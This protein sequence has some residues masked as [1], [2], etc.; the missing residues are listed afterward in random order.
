MIGWLFGPAV[1]AGEWWRVITSAFLH[2]SFIHIGFN[3]YVLWAIGHP[4]LEGIGRV[5]FLLVYL[6]GLL[7]ASFAVLAFD[8]TAP[9]LGASG[10]VLGLAGAL[11]AVLWSRGINITQTSLGFVLLLNL[12]LP[13]LIGG[14][15]F[16]GH[17]GGIF[18]GA[19][20]GWVVGWLPKYGR[21]QAEVAG[22]LVALCA[23]MAG[24]V[25]Y[26]VTSQGLL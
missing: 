13:L 1:E 3:M 8:Y 2:G 6:A 11:A 5:R 17:F 18:A 16:W 15:S 14:I 9:T 12:G 21:S 7:G 19:A 26:A 22:A 4:L 10:A 23:L 24:G 25:F 20:A